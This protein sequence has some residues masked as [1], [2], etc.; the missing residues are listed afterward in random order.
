[1]EPSDRSIRMGSALDDVG[2]R[3][4]TEGLKSEANT[5][6]P[7]WAMQQRNGQH[8]QEPLF[9]RIPAV[10]TSIQLSWHV[11]FAPTKTAFRRH[12][13]FG[14]TS[15]SAT[16][17]LHHSVGPPALQ[18]KGPYLP[19]LHLAAAAVAS[20]NAAKPYFSGFAVTQNLLVMWKPYG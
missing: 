4:P 17:D 10:V 9:L 16:A 6:L 2:S 13:G 1:M 11:D 3:D 19:T 20:R 15:D 7:Q 18:K 12:R 8:A 14:V 5:M